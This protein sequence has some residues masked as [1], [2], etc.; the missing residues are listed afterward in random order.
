MDEDEKLLMLGGIK[1]DIQYNK[2]SI[3]GLEKAC[4]SCLV[5]RVVY[6][7]VAVMGLAVVGALIALVLKGQK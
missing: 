4:E 3:A 1:S 2:E 7:V 5:K 6:G